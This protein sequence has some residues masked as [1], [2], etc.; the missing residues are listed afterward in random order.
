M[1][2]GQAQLL[3]DSAQG[4][5]LGHA[6]RETVEQE[7]DFYI[8]APQPLANHGDGHV[9]GHQLSLV[10]VGLGGFAKLGVVLDVVAEHIAGGDMRDIEQVDQFGGL[11][12]LA[13]SRRSEK[14]DVL[15]HDILTS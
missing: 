1:V 9:V 13:G 6:A 11:G 14:Y 5:G 15:G 10:G 2:Q 3:E 8:I 7:T 12:A 4:F